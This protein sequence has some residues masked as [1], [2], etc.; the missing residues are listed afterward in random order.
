MANIVPLR[1]DRCMARGLVC[2]ESSVLPRERS[3]HCPIVVN[4][5]VRPPGARPERGGMLGRR[6]ARLRGMSR[7]TDRRRQV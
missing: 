2:S 1:I 4:L 6:L 3:D 5:S 7:L